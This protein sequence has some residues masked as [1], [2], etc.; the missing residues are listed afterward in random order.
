MEYIYS[1]AALIIGGALSWFYARSRAMAGSRELEKKLE[2]K[3]EKLLMAEANLSETESRLENERQAV[4]EL[5]KKLAVA[6]E[7]ERLLQEKY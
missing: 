2:V 5:N 6:G 4:S 3:K 7:R 1:A